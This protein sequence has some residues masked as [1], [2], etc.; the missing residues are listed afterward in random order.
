MTL[1][2]YIFYFRRKP[3]TTPQEFKEYY[4]Q[5]H[6]PLLKEIAGDRFPLSHQ[7]YYLVRD[8]TPKNPAP[9]SDSDAADSTEVNYVPRVLSGAADDFP[10]DVYAELTF[11]DT[12]HL[13]AFLGR[14]GAQGKRIAEDQENFM[15]CTR[16]YGAEVEGPFG[17]TV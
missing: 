11:E 4:E 15:D 10:W 1:P 9:S 7:R 16:V 8:A 13:H 6:L 12:Q 3:G 14:L 5:H 17:S 2:R